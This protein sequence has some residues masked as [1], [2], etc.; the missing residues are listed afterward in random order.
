MITKYAGL[1]I[2]FA[3]LAIAYGQACGQTEQTKVNF[4][5]DIRPIL[6]SNCLRCHGPD[7]EEGGFRVD[8]RDQVL[9]QIEPG[10]A[11][12]SDFYDYLV[13]DDEDLLMPPPDDGGPLD[14]SDIRL[15]K[16]WINEGANWPAEIQ[17]LESGKAEEAVPAGE[18]EPN[19]SSEDPP[20]QTPEKTTI[21][22][23]K[24]NVW[25]AIGLLHPASVHLPAGLL[26]AAGLFALLSLRGNFVMSDC[27]YYCLWLG[28]ITAVAACLTGWWFV[29]SEYPRE[30]VASF[31]DLRNTDHRVFWH[32]TTAI[33][34]T[35]LSVFLSLFA[36][37]A[38][39]RDPDDG[40]AWKLGLILL[41]IFIGFV[42]HLGGK[43][44]W[45]P[46]HYDELF[47]V[48]Q[49]YVPGMAA[50]QKPDLRPVETKTEAIEGA[51]PE[52]TG[53]TSSESEASS[54]SESPST[55]QSTSWRRSAIIQSTAV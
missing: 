12:I 6:E 39:N 28:T 44:T 9:E 37:S 32:R 11:E 42:G 16:N 48:I 53:E 21:G 27:A 10:D 2:A 29:L 34:A 30:T 31:D 51:E 50:D 20:Q 17:L 23:D 3:L 18:A 43:L 5:N 15:V 22:P 4:A 46:S 24:P 52:G 1:I 49:E 19:I 47:E 54:D 36:A 14:D 35:V 38:R 8:D 25:R 7:E 33:I 26:M 55:D 40:V 13:T 41:A 45:K